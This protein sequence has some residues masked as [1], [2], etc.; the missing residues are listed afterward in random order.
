MPTN[1]CKP[2][3]ELTQTNIDNFWNKVDRGGPDECWPW[4]GLK[5]ARGYGKMTVRG[6]TI[7]A[8]R[9]AFFLYH[10]IDP[11]PFLVCHSCDNPKCLNGKHLFRGTNAINSADMAAKGRA[12]S[13]ANN[14]VHLHP[15]RVARGERQGSA[16]LTAEKVSLIRDLYATG[17]HSMRSLAS[18]FSVSPST[19]ARVV[20]K[21]HWTHVRSY[22]IS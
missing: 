22:H 13:G 9:I 2:L 19:I 7:L 1:K 21:T 16:K 8:H 18:K 11:F 17:D 14:G 20:L 12:A 6:K 5:H 10:G 15:E 4:T 3:P